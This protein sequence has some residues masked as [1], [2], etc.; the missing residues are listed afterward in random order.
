[1]GKKIRNAKTE[2]VPYVLVLGDKEVETKTVTIE[3]R[4]GNEGAVSVEDFL[5]RLKG[6]ID[7]R[8]L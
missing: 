4:T 1:L 3:S 8:K 2:K 6:E 5:E 7:E